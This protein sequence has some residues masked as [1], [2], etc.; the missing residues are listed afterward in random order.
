MTVKG[1]TSQACA[2]CKYQRRKCASDCALAPYFPPDKPKMFQNAH[3]LFGVSNILKILK[4]LSPS[5]K[6]DAM[7]SINFQAYL[8]EKFPVH[9]CYGYICQLR[10]QIDQIQQ[11]L[12]AV[13]TQLALYRQQH[14][15]H[16]LSSSSSPPPQHSPSSQLQLGMATSPT[17]NNSLPFFHHSYNQT[18]NTGISLDPNNGNNI[19]NNVNAYNTAVYVDSKDN[20]VNPLWI[21][22]QNPY[23]NA[24]NTSS[25]NNSAASVSQAPLLISQMLPSQQE[26]TETP[27]DYD[28][29]PPF[30]DTIDDRQSYIDSKEAYDSS[31]EDSLKGTTQSMS[32]FRIMN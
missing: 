23:N 7:Y 25:N 15:N 20:I 16:L 32:M 24:S 26:L 8:R 11:E 2:A 31:S 6:N 21:Q 22:N 13:Q 5:Q 19:S 30:F 29:I 3:R 18:F 28:E 9:G 4:Q 1:G 12:L 27:Q 10:F 14:H 17:T